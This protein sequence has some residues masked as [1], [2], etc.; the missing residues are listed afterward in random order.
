[1][2][3][4]RFF[5]ATCQR[6]NVRFAVSPDGQFIA[7]GSEDGKAYAWDI[8]SGFEVPSLEKWQIGFKHITADI[9][10]NRTYNMVA[11]AGFGEEYPIMIYVYEKSPERITKDLEQ[12]VPREEK[13]VLGY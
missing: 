5:G 7:T 8:A 1:M 9:S 2:I 11:I 10:W 3:Y 6:F 4:A 12:F 13:E